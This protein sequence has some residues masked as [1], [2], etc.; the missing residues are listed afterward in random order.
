VFGYP[1][2]VVKTRMQTFPKQYNNIN[3]SVKII[4]R[5]EGMRSFY[6][7]VSSPLMGSI[8]SEALQ[9]TVLRKIKIQMQHITGQV[10][11]LSNIN[12]ILSAI[13]TGQINSFVLT[14]MELIKI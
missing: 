8:F 13:I 2:D 5:K 1:F 6:Y 9:L 4:A 7:G 11:E 12:L 10:D 3:R 14:P